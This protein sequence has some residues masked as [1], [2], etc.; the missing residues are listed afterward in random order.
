[1]SLSPNPNQGIFKI[2]LENIVN[3]HLV[4]SLINVQGQLI[5]EVAVSSNGNY[6]SILFEQSDLPAGLY[7][8]KVQEGQQMKTIKINEQPHISDQISV[9]S[10]NNLLLF[11]YDR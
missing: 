4:L 2:V 9:K 11:S 8:L 7:F 3:R 6:Q 1:M 5:E 10:V